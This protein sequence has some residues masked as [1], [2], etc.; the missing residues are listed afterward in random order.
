M[1]EGKWRGYVD[2]CEERNYDPVNASVSVI[3]EFFCYLHEE[4][5]LALSTIEGYRTTIGQTLRNAGGEDIGQNKE[6]AELF[7][8]FARERGPNRTTVVPWDLSLV[9]MSLTT[10]PYEPMQTA[11]LKFVTWKTVFLLA[12][13][14]GKRRSEIH[15]L[16]KDIMH[17]EDWESITLLPDP[18]F[19]SKTQLAQ[20]GSELLNSVTVEALTKGLQED[21]SLCVV[22]A[23]RYYLDRTEQ[24]RGERRRLFISYKT[25]FNRDIHMNTV[26]SW[27]KAVINRAYENSSEK[28][29]EITGVKA[30]QVRAVA[31]SWAFYSNASIGSIMNACSWKNAS[32]FTLFYLKHVTLMR[33]NRYHLGPVVAASQRVEGFIGPSEN[34]PQENGLKD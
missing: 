2:W 26:S 8:N 10:D 15:A 1:Y 3:A 24:I 13:A 11:D 28:D 29:L 5:N 14:S 30:H 4:K 31:A 18:E 32:T 23:L 19:L 16:T 20:K 6:L 33:N 12:L 22:R 7:A 34:V 25:G 21:K 17:T 27:I 9:L